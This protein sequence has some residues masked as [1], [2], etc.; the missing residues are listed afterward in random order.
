M[1]KK[2]LLTLFV[3]ILLPSIIL[4]INDLRQ[5]S[6]E[7]RVQNDLVKVKDN[8][9]VLNKKDFKVIV[10]DDTKAKSGFFGFDKGLVKKNT[11]VTVKLV[12]D[13]GKGD[14]WYQILL[15][16]KKVYIN[17]LCTDTNIEEIKPFL[18][19]TNDVASIMDKV[20]GKEVASLFRGEITTVNGWRYDRS[21]TKWY[22]VSAND[23]KGYLSSDFVEMRYK[24]N[25]KVTS[26]ESNNKE[27]FIDAKVINDPLILEDVSY[28]TLINKFNRLSS[29][30]RPSDLVEIK[31][32]NGNRFSLRQEAANQFVKLLEDADKKG[33]KYT[34]NAGYRDRGKQELKYDK[35]YKKNPS[36]AIKRVAYPRCSEHEGGF[37]VDVF[38]KGANVDNYFTKPA[39][40][41]LQDNAHKYGYILRYPKDKVA[42]TNITYEP[43]HYR[44]VGVE[45][46]TYLKEN[47]LTLEEYYLVD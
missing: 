9:D 32:S 13:Y 18:I 11:I 45:L 10:T 1:K 25:E 40:K 5:P 2:I 34:V 41:F 26:T 37:A 23:K 28:K 21:G 35:A 8:T 4:E 17:S 36:E 20:K 33:I 3:I 31:D 6:N 16:K 47:D 46:A 14:I 30:Y 27:G 44:Y 29:G 15:N 38:F 12:K 19:R 39:G 43:W 24:E 7:K 42:I 22:L